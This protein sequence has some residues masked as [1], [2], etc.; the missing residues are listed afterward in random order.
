MD[1]KGI[2][3]PILTPMNKDESVNYDELKNQINRMIDAGIHG[4]FFFGTNGEAYILTPEEKRK[5]LE[6]GIE[7]V[8]HRVP[9]YAGTGCVGTKDTIEMSRMAESLGADV[10]SIISPYFAAISQDEVLAHYTAVAKSVKTPIVIYNIPPRTGVNIAPATIEKLSHIDN[11]VG[12]KD[13]SGNFDNMLQYIEATKYRKDFAVLSGNDSLIL[14]C[15]VAGGKGS[16]A[17]CA[18]VFPENMVQIYESFIKGD[19]EKAKFYQS[20]IRALRAVFK[21][22]NPNTIIKKATGLLGYPIGDC[23]LPFNGLSNEG[24]DALKKVLAEYEA[25]G[26]K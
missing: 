19:M 26:T 7:T 3:V 6:I 21:Y 22:G 9:V 23:R 8:N 13:S 15:L 18:N 17:G 2:I 20:N 14:W 4:I 1:I 11:I 10:L 25:K 5:I 24:F 12:A 16:I